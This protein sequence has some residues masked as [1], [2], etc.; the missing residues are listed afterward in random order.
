M[1]TKLRHFAQTSSPRTIA[2]DPSP[3]FLSIPT[4]TQIPS[5]SQIDPTMVGKRKRGR[6]PKVKHPRSTALSSFATK[7]RPISRILSRTPT[8]LSDVDR[9]LRILDEFQGE[10][11]SLRAA[12]EK[13]SEQNSSIT[14]SEVTKRQAPS[15]LQLSAHNTYTDSSNTLANSVLDDD[16][17]SVASISTN[18]SGQRSSARVTRRTR[19]SEKEKKAP[20]RFN[21]LFNFYPPKLVVRDGELVPE[22]SLSVKDMDR[23]SISNLPESHP[24][25]HWRVGEPVSE[26]DEEES[27][28]NSGRKRKI[29]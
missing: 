17:S 15:L 27:S 4:V 18:G 29:V 11:L 16:I 25:M 23:A 19:A 9:Q 3:S 2:N 5:T 24:F 26:K 21:D 8:P 28:K 10:P 20:F 6:P 22:Q 13:Q 12:N 14:N 1:A 7:K